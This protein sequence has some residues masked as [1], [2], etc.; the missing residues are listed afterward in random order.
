MTKKALVPK[1]QK[2]SSAWQSLLPVPTG[3]VRRAILTVKENAG[4]YRGHYPQ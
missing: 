4:A 1:Q 3:P 2:W